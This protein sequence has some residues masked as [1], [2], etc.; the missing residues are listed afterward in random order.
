M[1]L[2][3]FKD[4]DIL[5]IMPLLYDQSKIGVVVNDLQRSKLAY[6]LFKLYSGVFMK[7]DIAKNDGAVSILRSFKKEDLLNYSNRIKVNNFELKWC[8]AFR[9]LWILKK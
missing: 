9:Y 7:S 1:T 6:L 4:E 2:H 3:H 5:D 8:W